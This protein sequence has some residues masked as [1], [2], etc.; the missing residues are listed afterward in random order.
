[1]CVIQV[2]RAILFRQKILS[3]P[4]CHRFKFIADLSD[5]WIN[6]SHRNDKRRHL[7]HWKEEVFHAEHLMEHEARYLWPQLPDTFWRSLCP[8]YLLFPQ[9][10]LLV[11]T[12]RYN[13]SIL[14]RGDRLKWCYTTIERVLT[15]HDNEKV[16]YHGHGQCH[17]S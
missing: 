14:E 2:R 17:A 10:F 5:C 6:F 4:T 3:D 11:C 12:R 9:D 8:S 16:E 15:Q 13:I 1:M 7:S